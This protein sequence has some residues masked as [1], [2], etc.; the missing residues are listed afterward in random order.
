M[1]NILLKKLILYIK[2]LYNMYVVDY[3]DFCDINST[4]EFRSQ[5]NI[6]TIYSNMIRCKKCGWLIRSKNRHDY[7]QC[8]CGACSIDGG[9]F[10][11]K[12]GCKDMKDVEVRTVFFNDVKTES[13]KDV[14]NEE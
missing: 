4:A 14:Y 12:I 2:E 8:Q 7:R 3:H 10:Y 6:G 9:S 5:L 11:V 1:E 13:N